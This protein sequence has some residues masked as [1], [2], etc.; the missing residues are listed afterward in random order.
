L[1]YGAVAAE[2]LKL[3]GPFVVVV[4]VVSKGKAVAKAQER[5]ARARNWV[6]ISALW[7]GGTG[8]R[9]VLSGEDVCVGLK[10]SGS[11]GL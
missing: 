6:F 1:G 3:D 9:S 8:A 7:R 10:G 2:E 11:F 5:V 4:L